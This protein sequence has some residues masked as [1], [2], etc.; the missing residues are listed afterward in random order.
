MNFVA[1]DSNKKKGLQNFSKIDVKMMK[2]YS[3]KL[4]KLKE[5]A[6]EIRKK[7]RDA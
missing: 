1:I 3:K 6:K 5:D 2:K 4:K 7:I